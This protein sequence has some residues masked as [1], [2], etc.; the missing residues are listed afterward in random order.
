M[1]AIHSTMGSRSFSSRGTTSATTE[2]T[3]FRMSPSV[4]SIAIDS[5]RTESRC[6]LAVILSSPFR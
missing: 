1:L 4:C 2:L 6:D 3:Y 5:T